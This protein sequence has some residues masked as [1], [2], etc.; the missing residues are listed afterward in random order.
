M[1]LTPYL[2]EAVFDP[3]AIEAMNAAFVDVCAHL[4]LA[5]RDDPFTQVVARKVVE[6]GGTGERDPKRIA[7]VVLQAIKQTDKLSA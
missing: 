6:V 2:K 5:I 1:P 4:Q 7:E 3:P